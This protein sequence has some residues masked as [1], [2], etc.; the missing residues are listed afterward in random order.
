LKNSGLNYWKLKKFIKKDPAT[1]VAFETAI[2]LF[3]DEK[4][5]DIK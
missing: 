1:G 2:Y 3:Q 4:G 5:T